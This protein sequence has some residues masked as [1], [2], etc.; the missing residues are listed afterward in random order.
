MIHSTPNSASIDYADV[1]ASELT[2]IAGQTV[3][4][5]QC[6]SIS[7]IQDSNV[8]EAQ[9]SFQLVLTA[10]ETFIIIP[11]GQDG[12]IIYVNEDPLDGGL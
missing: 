9:E 6:I 1:V 8:L 11:S 10:V 4:D 2:F 5:R 7:I 12:I 3:G